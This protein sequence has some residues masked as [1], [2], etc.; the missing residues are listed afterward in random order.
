MMTSFLP[1]SRVESSASPELGFGKARDLTICRPEQN[2]KLRVLPET[3]LL[4]KPKR[5]S[6]GLLSK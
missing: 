4:L 6:L 2:E 5:N 1:S 3:M